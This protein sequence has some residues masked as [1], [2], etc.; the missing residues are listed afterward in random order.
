[1]LPNSLYGRTVN[2]KIPVEMISRLDV[3]RNSRYV[4]I[5]YKRPVSNLSVWTAVRKV[6]LVQGDPG[7]ATLLCRESS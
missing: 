4:D 5:V 7:Y 3:D 1:M 2:A 6:L